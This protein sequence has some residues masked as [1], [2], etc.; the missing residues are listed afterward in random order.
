MSGSTDYRASN[1]SEKIGR[2]VRVFDLAT[3]RRML[4]LVERIV[5]DIG[6]ARQDLTE[7]LP[8]QDRLDR[9]KRVLSWPERS[10]RY[11]LR[12]EIAA[13][14]DSLQD[15]LAELDHLGIEL[16][17]PESGRIGFP[18]LVN[19]RKAYFSWQPGDETV[20]FWHYAGETERQPIPAGWSKV[21]NLS[22]S[23][24]I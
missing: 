3:A 10:R 22:L 9:Q 15:A 12:D 11:L 2:K 17:N 14:E 18:T 21:V 19:H 24:T 20:Q 6:H 4:T 5:S 23:S 1:P 8:E 16:L 13:R 7:M